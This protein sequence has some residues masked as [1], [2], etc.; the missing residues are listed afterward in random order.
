[1]KM[2]IATKKINCLSCKDFRIG[3]TFEVTLKI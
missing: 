1:M 3:I 2:S